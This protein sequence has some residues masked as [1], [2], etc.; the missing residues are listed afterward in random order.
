LKILLLADTHYGCRQDNFVFYDYQKKFVDNVL[1]RY[2]KQEN[3]KHFI[4]L[5]DL[6]DNRKTIN[7]KTLH[8]MKTD[9]LN[10]IKDLGIETHWIV[11]NHDAPYKNNLNNNAVNAFV[12]F[13]EIHNYPHEINIGD[14]KFLMV[15]WIC[16]EN[17]EETLNIIK[18]SRAD[19]CMGH[20][21]LV[22][23][24]ESK[25][26]L[27]KNGED[28]RLF[29]IFDAVFSGH[30]HIRSNANNICYIGS[31]FEFTWADYMDYRGFA[32]LDTETKKVQYIKNPY[33]M[34]TKIEYDEDHIPEISKV[35]DSYCRIVVK[36]KLSETKFSDFI[37]RIN[38]LGVI[39][40]GIIDASFKPVE[41]T[42]EAIIFDDTR[43]TFNTYLN[44][45]DISN[46]EGVKSIF[47]EVYDE[48]QNGEL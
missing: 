2:I 23:F 41:L 4:H 22:G 8:R 27:S 25:G 37:N 11:G 13:G 31:A 33:H 17:K 45:L 14:F 29:S 6:V 30:F 48:A 15:P 39:D 21:E 42:E 20:L 40:L 43:N 38:D 35:K 10:P 1:L 18:H 3:I 24:E 34:F 9:F 46:K 32:I 7:Y 47:D 26:R 12:D 19:F 28:Q 5:G 44:S 36:N 16:S